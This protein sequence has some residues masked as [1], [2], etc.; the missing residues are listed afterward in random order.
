MTSY[1]WP[2]NNTHSQIQRTKHSNFYQ[3]MGF[4]SWETAVAN[5]KILFSTCSWLNLR[6][7]NPQIGRTDCIYRKKSVHNWTRIVQTHV[8]QGQMHFFLFLTYS[9]CV[10]EHLFCFIFM[11]VYIFDIVIEYN[12]TVIIEYK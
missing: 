8:V 9:T 1:S 11:Y 4:C 6:R 7:Q 3:W 5:M 10:I 12:Y 2:L